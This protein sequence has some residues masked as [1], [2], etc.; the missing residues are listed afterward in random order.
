MEHV[1]HVLLGVA[2]GNRHPDK[3][4]YL[5]FN[6]PSPRKTDIQ[7]HAYYLMKKGTFIGWCLL[8]DG[9]TYCHDIFMWIKGD[10][11]M[12]WVESYKDLIQAMKDDKS[13]YFEPRH[14]KKVDTVYA[15]YCDKDPFFRFDSQGESN[16]SGTSSP[17]I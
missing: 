17:T 10:P 6:A 4:P 16:T 15:Y 11:K 7:R 14:F 8:N 3:Y 9:F 13:G 1:P 12:D 2:R 5:T